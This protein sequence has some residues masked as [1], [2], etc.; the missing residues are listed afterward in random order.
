M[1]VI[2]VKSLCDRLLYKKWDYG[3]CVFGKVR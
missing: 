1:T 2:R 3:L